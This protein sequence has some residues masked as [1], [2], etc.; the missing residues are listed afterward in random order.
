MFKHRQWLS[1]TV[2]K[3]DQRRFWHLM[4]TFSTQHF[5]T[6]PSTPTT[7]WGSALRPDVVVYP[8]CF[9]LPI[10]YSWFPPVTCLCVRFEAGGGRGVDVS[11]GPAGSVP[12]NAGDWLGVRFGQEGGARPVSC[13]AHIADKLWN[14]GLWGCLCHVGLDGVF[15]CLPAGGIMLLRT[16]SQHCRARPRTEPTPTAAR[17]RPTC[18]CS[19]RQ[20]VASTHR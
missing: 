18:R 19:W 9:A 16:R 13:S 10:S 1:K 14:F 12:E 3:S 15:F 5:P 7:C 2:K 20:L 4:P 8:S 6:L 17:S 11:T